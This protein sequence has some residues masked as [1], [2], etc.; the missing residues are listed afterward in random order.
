MIA[1]DLALKFVITATE[2]QSP[3]DAVSSEKFRYK[4]F[5]G[6]ELLKQDIEPNYTVSYIVP[7]QFLAAWQILNNYPGMFSFIFRWGATAVTLNHYR[8][9]ESNM[10]LALFLALLS[11]PIYSI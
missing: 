5:E 3:P 1:A 6:G 2:E 11:I 8:E 7:L 9:N 10:N 4:D